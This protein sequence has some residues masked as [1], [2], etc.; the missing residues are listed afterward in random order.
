MLVLSRLPGQSI[1]IG[2][3]IEITVVSVRPDKVRIGIRAPKGIPVHRK[4]IFDEI[5]HANLAASDA[6]R[7]ASERLW[8]A[9]RPPSPPPG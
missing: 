8:R 4:E 6:Q 7:E 1:M 3:G 2:D 9:L 5:Q